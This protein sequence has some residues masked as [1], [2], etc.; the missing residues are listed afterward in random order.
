VWGIGFND[1]I[2]PRQYT[3]EECRDLVEFLKADG[4]SVMIGSPTG[5]RNLERDALPD[6]A[7]HEVFKMADV[8]SPWTVGRYRNPKTVATHAQKFW[9]PDQI[10]C[11][12]NDLSY[13]PVIFPGFSWHHLKGAEL[14]AIPRLKGEFFWSQVVAAK[15]AGAKMLYVDMFDEVDEGTA[16]FKVTNTPPDADGV[17]FVTYEGLPSDHYLF[18]AGQAARVIRGDIPPTD[19]I[20]TRDHHSI[21]P[22]P[23]HHSR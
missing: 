8:V 13:L 9:G 16:I 15:Q 20:P 10:W 4:C 5:W 19:P 11:D 3:L 2:K 18:L 7:L 1:G 21:N 12:E 17:P 23:I 14:D 6:P 22:Q